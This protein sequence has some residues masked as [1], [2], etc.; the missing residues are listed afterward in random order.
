MALVTVGMDMDGVLYPF[1]EA[2]N[3]LY[4]MYG[5]EEQ[6]FDSWLDF[7][8]MDQD[9]VS[10]VWKNPE[11]F[12]AS[13]PYPG[14]VS[15]MEQLHE[16]PDLDVVIMT[17]PGRDI[18]ITFPA[19]WA[20][21]QKW[22]PWVEPQD[23]IVAYHKELVRVDLLVEDFPGNIKKWMKSN[24][25]GLAM[26]VKQPW[27]QTEVERLSKKGVLISNEGISPTISVV[28]Q[29]LRERRAA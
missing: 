12:T 25:T 24:P 19:K 13:G 18:P 16:T 29:L 8:K 9:I 2:F 26:M 10:K 11:L 28:N 17:N 20:W 5:G 3:R 27:N 15:I 4:M 7:G 14:V 21:I 22:L 23:M 1:D 6:N